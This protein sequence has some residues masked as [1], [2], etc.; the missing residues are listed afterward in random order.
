MEG[1]VFCVYPTKLAKLL[2]DVKDGFAHIALVDENG[3]PAPG[4]QVVDV[5]VRDPDGN[6]H[7]E[8]G[9]YVMER[10]RL[11]VPLRF[12]DDDPKGSFFSRWKVSAKELTTGFT[13]TTSFIK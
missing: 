11:K 9:R 4:R 3:K 6:L 1:K 13:E 10:G 5:E 12:A 8:T 7:D 2:V